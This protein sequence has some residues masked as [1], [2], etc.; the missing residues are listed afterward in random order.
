MEIKSDDILFI[1]SWALALAFSRAEI[2]CRKFAFSW[3][4][5]S[6]RS[7]ELLAFIAGG[8]LGFCAVERS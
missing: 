6:I 4:R 2:V 1:V 3:A 7:L 5:I 8:V